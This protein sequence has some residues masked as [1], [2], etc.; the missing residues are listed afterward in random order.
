MNFNFFCTRSWI[1]QDLPHQ[2]WEAQTAD[3]H[4]APFITRFL[5]NKVFFLFNNYLRCYLTYLSPDYVVSMVTIIGLVL[6]L[7]GLYFLVSK[8][9]YLLL[10]FILLAPLF[11]VLE[12]PKDKNYQGI[13]LLTSL[14][15]TICYGVFSMLHDAWE[16]LKK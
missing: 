2:I 15:S 12:I 7:V 8:K 6:F 11:P 9:N 3:G 13:I 5:H 10:G 14:L 16:K 4:V 1:A